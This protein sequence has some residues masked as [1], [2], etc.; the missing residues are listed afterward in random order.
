MIRRINICEKE[1]QK[2]LEYTKKY[3][4]AYSIAKKIEGLIKNT[5][6]HPPGIAICNIKI[7][8]V[9]PLHQ[10]KRENSFLDL[11]WEM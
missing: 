1:S 7:D 11:K 9:I 3:S 10:R 5:G 4:K 8:D 2:F 6:V